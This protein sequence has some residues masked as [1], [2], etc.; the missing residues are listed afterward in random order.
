M[1][2]Q[3]DQAQEFEQVRRDDALLEQSRKPSMPPL[4][5]CYNCDEVV[6][7]GCF[8]NSYCRDDYQLREKQ[9]VQRI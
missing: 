1:T 3:L 4:G 7:V 5:F 2:D 8:C 6:F 9:A